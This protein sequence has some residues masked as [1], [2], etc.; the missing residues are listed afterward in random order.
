MFGYFARKK[1]EKE[2]EAQELIDFYESKRLAREAI[3]EKERAESKAFRE[4]EALSA[5][6]FRELKLAMEDYKTAKMV[7]NSLVAK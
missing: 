1:K 3:Y 2:K 7:L 5:A 6:K 4:R